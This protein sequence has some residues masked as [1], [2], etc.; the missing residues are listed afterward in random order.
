MKN[1]ETLPNF[2]IRYFDQ[3]LY[4]VYEAIAGKGLVWFVQRLWFLT[5]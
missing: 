5:L 2:E 3:E 4:G 1:G